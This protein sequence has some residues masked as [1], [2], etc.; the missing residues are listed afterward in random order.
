MQLL[1]SAGPAESSGMSVVAIAAYFSPNNSPPLLFVRHS[2]AD[3][4]MGE[5]GVGVFPPVGGGLVFV[6]Y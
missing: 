2:T 1:E 6:L 5:G 4:E 3:F